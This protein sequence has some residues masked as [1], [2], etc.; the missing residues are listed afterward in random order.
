MK[1]PEFLKTKKEK[2]SERIDKRISFYGSVLG[3]AIA[4]KERQQYN[5]QKELEAENLRLKNELLKSQ[6]DKKDYK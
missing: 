1:K 2:R 4:I 3:L 5:T 6:I